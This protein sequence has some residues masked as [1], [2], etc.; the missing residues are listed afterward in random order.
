MT[1]ETL[2]LEKVQAATNLL[3]EI[4]VLLP[5]PSPTVHKLRVVWNSET[6]TEAPLPRAIGREEAVRLR[7]ETERPRQFRPDPRK[8][9]SESAPVLGR[10]RQ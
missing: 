3:L 5:S 10:L 7:R 6:Q 8:R 1:N 9:I 4:M 2:I